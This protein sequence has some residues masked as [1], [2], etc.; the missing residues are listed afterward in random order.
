MAMKSWQFWSLNALAVLALALWATNLWFSN[1][2]QQLQLEANENQRVLNQGD[3]INQLNNQ[4]AQA[5]ATAAVQSDDKYI[6]ALLADNGITFTFNPAP[7]AGEG[8]NE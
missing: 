1:G 7:E 8:S 2:N 3:Q 4:L 6:R 5:L